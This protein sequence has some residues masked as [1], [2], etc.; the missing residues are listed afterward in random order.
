VTVQSW[1]LGRSDTSAEA[2]GSYLPL[3]CSTSFGS[4][5]SP[6][7]LMEAKYLFWIN[8]CRNVLLTTQVHSE[9]RHENLVCLLKSVT[10]QV[11]WDRTSTNP[12]PSSAHSVD[13]RHVS[14]TGQ[15]I[16]LLVLIFIVITKSSPNYEIT[17]TFWLFNTQYLWN[18]HVLRNLMFR[19]YFCY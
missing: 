11:S 6:N 8:G 17:C 2:L 10:Q 13:S 12:H 19:N 14:N 4:T 7:Q 9:W 5:Q 1:K 16:Y 3:L 15:Y 18:S